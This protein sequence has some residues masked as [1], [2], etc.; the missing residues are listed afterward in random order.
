MKISLSMEL[1]R[2]YD[3]IAMP[4]LQMLPV[5]SLKQYQS[6]L[7]TVLFPKPV[8]FHPELFLDGIGD[9]LNR[10]VNIVMVVS[11]DKDIWF[12]V[13]YWYTVSVTADLDCAPR[14]SAYCSQYSNVC[15][16]N[17]TCVEVLRVGYWVS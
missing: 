5:L 14:L 10:F 7:L 3:T 4:D 8:P 11:V 1:L 15:L 9:Y 2:F 6:S 13:L 12:A 17:E 16:H